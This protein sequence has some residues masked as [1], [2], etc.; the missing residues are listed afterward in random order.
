M[1]V[2]DNVSPVEVQVGNDSRLRLVSNHKSIHGLTIN[3]GVSSFLGWNQGQT[4]SDPDLAIH[5][6]NGSVISVNLDF[7]ETLAD[8]K[9]KIEA[10]AAGPPSSSFVRGGQNPTARQNSSGGNECVQS[11]SKRVITK[12]LVRSAHNSVFWGQLVRLRITQARQSTSQ[13]KVI[14]LSER[15]CFADRLL[16]SFLYQLQIARSLR[17]SV[18]KRRMS[19][20]LR[21]WAYIDLGIVDGRLDFHVDASLGLVD[22]DHPDTP[23]NE[24]LDGKL[25]LKDFAIGNFR[26]LLSPSFTYAGSL[27]LPIDGSSLDALL[28]LNLPPLR[29]TP[30]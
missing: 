19:I 27:E 18:S 4:S 17:I 26:S 14:F 8:I 24:S 10:A 12:A 21:L 3:A 22:V 13:I 2:V 15:R 29:S 28:P 20:W 23:V 1:S 6:R 5:L 9:N 7:S 16:T 25:R 30:R 11:R